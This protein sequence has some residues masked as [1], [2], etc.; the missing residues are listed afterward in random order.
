[1]ARLSI[2]EYRELGRGMSGNVLHLPHEPALVEQTPVDFSGGEQKSAAFHA[3]TRYVLLTADA[4]CHI[5]FGTDPTADTDNW[6]LYAK[7][8]QGYAVTYAQG[9]KISVIG[10]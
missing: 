1:M 2:K 6:P 4:D 10:A 7:S 8:Y 9:M 3:A 5:L